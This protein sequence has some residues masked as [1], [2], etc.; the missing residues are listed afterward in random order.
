M[1]RLCLKNCQNVEDLRQCAARRAHKM[2]FDYIDGAAGDERTLAENRAAFDAYEL[3]FRVLVDVDKVDTSTTLLGHRLEQPFLCSPAAGNRLFHTQ[4]ERAVARAAADLGIAYSLS[5]LSSVSIEEIAAL[6]KTA[7]QFFQLYVWKDRGL[8]AEMLSRARAAGFAALI[9]T[10]DFPITGKRERDARNG[11]GIPPTLGAKQVWEAMK[12]PAWTLDYLR[13]PPIGY[14]NLAT[15]TPAM[16]LASFVE[17]QLHAGFDWSDAEWLL[18]E[19]G[20]PSV[21]KGVVRT[22]DARRAVATG[23]NA[24]AISNHGGRQLDRSAAPIARLRDVLEA[25]QGDAE[26]IVDGGVRRGIDVLTA[27]ALGADAVSFA[28]PYLYGL[29]A[30]GYAGVR[31]ALDILADE[32]ARDMALLGA[33]SLAAVDASCVKRR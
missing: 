26:I 19:W 17:N 8:V 10:V 15:D 14:A 31:R 12:R 16:S 2:V 13:G 5:T 25:V 27:L 22:D 6:R 18:G 29:A 7:P 24:I 28:R 9:L 4:G 23:F 11:F 32:V 30:G 3:L 33:S 1:R 21:I 20:G